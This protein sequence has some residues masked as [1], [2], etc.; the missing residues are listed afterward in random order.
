M[1]I[2]IHNRQGSFS[3]HWISYCERN[4]VPFKIVNA[5][6]DNIMNQLADCDALM[7]H[8][9][10]NKISDRIVAQKILNSVEQSGKVVF[11]DFNTGWHFDDKL[12]QKYLFECLNAPS[13]RTYAFLDKKNALKWVE[14]TD[15][16]KVFKLRGGAG[17]SNVLLVQSKDEAR[18]LIKKCFGKGF[19]E[20]PLKDTLKYQWEKYKSGRIT[21]RNMFNFSVVTVWHYFTRVN[22]REHGYAYFQDFIP[23]NSYDIRIVV[24]GDKAFGIKR[25]C[26]D[27]DFRASGSGKLV[28]D[29]I[30]IDERCIK[31]SFE[32]ADRLKTQCV[33]FDWIFDKDGCPLIV[34][35]SYGFTPDAYMYCDGFWTR[36]LEWHAG[37]GFDFC[38]WMVEDV[39]SRCVVNE[40]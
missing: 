18:K 1:R 5:Y 15:F 11:P 36:D 16:P 14:D 25:L 12:G 26:R 9:H 39:I 7:W 38:G 13:V 21:L 28:Y 10:H 20:M 8:Y 33:G 40:I 32:V 31:L 24:I 2:A 30:E 22:N 27:N 3:E 4:G 23:N 35:M 6:K 37:T 17:S 34:E 29:H 19:K